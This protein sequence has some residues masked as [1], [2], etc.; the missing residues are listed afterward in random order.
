MLIRACSHFTGHNHLIAGLLLANL[1]SIAATALF[2]RFVTLYHGLQ[3][4]NLATILL[5]AFPG[6]LFFS[7]IYTE[8][9][10]FLLIVLFFWFLFKE[11]FLAAAVVGFFLPLTKAIGIF[12]LLPALAYL[13]FN[14]KPHDAPLPSDGRGIKGEGW[15][16]YLMLDGPLL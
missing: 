15:L 5:L 8:S 1:L 9:L 12:C 11:N 7:F 3:T 6:A 13:V 16:K 2:H 10:F 4:A 14:K